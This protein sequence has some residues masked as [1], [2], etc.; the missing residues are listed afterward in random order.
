MNMADE[1]LTTEQAAA[2]LGYA[3]Q[4]LTDKRWR[5]DGPPFLKLSRNC[6][7]YSKAALIEWA[8]SKTVVGKNASS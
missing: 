8:M 6:V 7:R 2:Y 4:T 1:M 3:P 5:G